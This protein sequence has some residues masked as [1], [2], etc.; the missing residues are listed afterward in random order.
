MKE[1]ISLIFFVTIFFVL[2]LFPVPVHAATSSCDLQVSM[3]NQD[4]YPA[5]QGDTVKLLF[6]VSGVQ[7]PSCN[8]AIFRLD[9]GYA[10]SLTQNNSIQILQG[11]TF[12]Q[13]YNGD[14]VLPYTLKVAKDAPDGDSQVEVFYSPGNTLSYSSATERFNVSVQDSRAS[15]EVYVSN[16][17]PT[18]RTI[19]FQILNTAKVDVKALTMQ[20]PEQGALQVKG[21]NT[22]IVGDLDSNEYT[23]ADFEGTP[24][25]GNISVIISYT[26]QAGVRRTVEQEVPYNSIYFTGRVSDQGGSSAITWIVVIIIVGGIAYWFYRRRKKKKKMMEERRKRMS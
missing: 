21:A 17:N 14:W 7:N 18:T 11:S 10:F 12:T 8:G 19:T 13:N 6:Q 20:I 9:P 26:D 1:K 16:Y 5:V 15:F 25:D 2:S 22:N 3:V 4:P 24:S 23:T